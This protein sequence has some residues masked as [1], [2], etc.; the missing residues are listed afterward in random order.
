MST[1]EGLFD[2]GA[3]TFPDTTLSWVDVRD[4]AD[5]HI[6]G[7]ENPSASGR[8]LLVERTSHISEALKI[9]RELYPALAL[10]EK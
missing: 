7:F 3:E 5:A 4:V 1:V 8:Y 9:L 2:A 10:P 6:Q